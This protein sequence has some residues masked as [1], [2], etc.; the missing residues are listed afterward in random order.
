MTGDVLMIE[1]FES[2]LIVVKEL[3]VNVY[4]PINIFKDPFAGIMFLV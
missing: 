4:P 1:E 3:L 2:E